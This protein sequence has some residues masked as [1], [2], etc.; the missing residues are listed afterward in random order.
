MSSV[1][2]SPAPLGLEED[3]LVTVFHV[4]RIGICLVD[5]GGRLL[6]VNPAFCDLVGYPAEELMGRH[7]TFAATDDFLPEA[8]RFYDALLRNS[9]RVPE[10]W[11]IRRR[12]G[13]LLDA[14]VSFRSIERKE[15][16]RCVVVTFTDITARKRA[17]ARIRELNRDLEV[18]RAQQMGRHRQVLLELA[19][20]DKSDFPSALGTILRG[21]AA[22]L[23]VARANYWRLS[24]DQSA[25]VCEMSWDAAGQCPIPGEV[26]KRWVER[27]YPSYFAAIR[28]NRCVVAHDAL[29]DPATAEFSATLLAPHGIGAMLD[30][31]VWQQGRMV[32][33]LCHEHLGPAR[34]WTPEEV[35]FAN[36]VGNMIALALEASERRAL[37]ESLRQTLTERETILR[38][39]LVGISFSIGRRHRWVNETFAGMLGYRPEEL[40]G[41]S[42]LIHFPDRHDWEEFGRTAY[43]ILAGGEPYSGE[44]R[45]KRKDGRLIHCQLY[46]RAMDPLDLERGAIWTFIDITERKRAEEEVRKTLEKERELNDLKSRFV[47]MTS[48]EFRTPLATILSSAELLKDYGERLPAS[49]KTELLGLIKSAVGRMTGMLDDVL[50]LGKAEAERLEYNPGPLD[51]EPFCT[52]LLD[53]IRRSDRDGHHFEFRRS[54]AGGPRLL[55]GKLLQHVLANLLD[56]AAKYSPPGSTIR[57]GVE[58]GPQATEFEVED[59]GIGIPPEDLGRLFET[60]HRGRNVRNVSG[61]GLG[62]AIVKKF[63]DLHGGTIR[64]NSEVGRGT[65][66]TVAIP[67]QEEGEWRAS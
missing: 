27:N 46:G 5:E 62:L 56:N 20:L 64:V 40:I 42:S 54:G 24:P 12:D 57:L 45:M 8:Q 25:I 14:L 18:S 22:G 32:G 19:Q 44:V 39:T 53:E 13:S 26:G 67:R 59:Q 52:A 37:Q 28:A 11:R 16:S 1:P 60:F 21:S 36:A 41:Q 55:D 61:T 6:Q 34:E 2:A 10:E 29:N 23:G 51:I 33:V 58:A 3:F 15:G 35:D 43:P 9:P 47:S 7:W 48:H 63:V 30:V 31:G 65:R 49:E 50:T 38:S 4:A 66:F 17:E